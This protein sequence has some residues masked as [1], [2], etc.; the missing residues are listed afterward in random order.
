[1][2]T[3]RWEQRP[4]RTLVRVLGGG[5][6]S[7]ERLDYWT[8]GTIPWVS[9]KDMKRDVVGDAEDHITERALRETAVQ[10]I[11]VDAVLVVVRG[12]ILSR[13]VPVALTAAPVT[14]NQDMKALVPHPALLG[15]YLRYALSGRA[16][17]LMSLVEEAGHGTKCLRSELLFNVQIAVPPLSDQRRIADFLDARCAAIDAAI[18]KKERMLEAAED[19]LSSAIETLVR[20]GTVAGRKLVR[21]DTAWIDHL[22]EGWRIERNGALFDERDSR[23]EPHLPVLSVS[24]VSGVTLRDFSNDR[25][26]PQMSDFAQYKVA[27]RN[28]IVFNKMRMWQGAVGVAPVDGLVSP[29][30]TVLRP[31]AGIDPNYF[32]A[33]FKIRAYTG[34]VSRY[35]HGIA[36]DR[37][38]IYWTEF[39]VIRSLVPPEVEQKEIAS[40]IG[41]VKTAS[42]RLTTGLTRSIAALREYRTALITAAVTGQ[43]EIPRMPTAEVAL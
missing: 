7:K 10:L 9:P 27:R 8:E 15:R 35:S 39:K 19:R 22:P 28:D 12:M 14:L 36:L 37:N 29:D 32:A 1:M 41:A 30:Y 38:R 20:R 18:E 21:V 3:S 43:F 6:P 26:Q 17:E 25:I 11:P 13:C 4:L 40:A 42:S 2:K 31:R 34:E 5:T 23:G 24:L 33:M 16:D